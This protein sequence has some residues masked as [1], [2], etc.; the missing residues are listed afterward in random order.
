MARPT[1]SR[2]TPLAITIADGWIGPATRQANT[3]LEIIRAS[4]WSGRELRAVLR[5]ELSRLAVEDP[6]SLIAM[7]ADRFWEA[8]EILEDGP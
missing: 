7:E 4:G 5:D 3:V 2:P 8:F 6:V 1:V